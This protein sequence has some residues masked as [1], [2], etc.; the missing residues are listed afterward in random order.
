MARKKRQGT[1]EQG[2]NLD[3]H[4]KAGYSLKT[5]QESLDR[6]KAELN[7]CYPASSDKDVKTIETAMEKVRL[8]Q[9][10][11]HSR[12]IAE[13]PEKSDDELLPVYLGRLP[14]YLPSR[15]A[16]END[17][18]AESDTQQQ[19]SEIDPLQPLVESM[20]SNGS[21]DLSVNQ[22]LSA[23]NGSDSHE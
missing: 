9:G 22:E 16:P 7:Y 23:E 13:F 10:L 11:M 8:T 19:E 3:K 5:V 6:I 2:F 1:P 21:S 17:E 20:S 12:L 15:T 4:Y 14:Q 18:T